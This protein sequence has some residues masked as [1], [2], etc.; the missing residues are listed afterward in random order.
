MSE[1]SDSSNAF[2][3]YLGVAA[4]F[5]ITAA[6]FMVAYGNQYRDTPPVSESLRNQRVELR[7]KVEGD[8]RTLISEYGKNADGTHRIPVDKAVEILVT[9][10]AAL[11]AAR[12]GAK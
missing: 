12:G 9:N 6:V 1:Q 11:D 3:T 5:A 2:L 10:P 7:K 8:S 4:C